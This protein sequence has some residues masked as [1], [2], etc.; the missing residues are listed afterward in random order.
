MAEFKWTDSQ[1]L[2]ISAPTDNI[3]VSAAAGSGKTAVLVERI[4]RMLSRDEHPLDIDRLVVI[5]FTRAAA[6]SMKNKI[7]KRLRD[8]C[9]E[10]P[11]NIYLRQQLMKVQHARICTIDSLCADIV[12]NNIQD[13]ELDPGFRLADEAEINLLKKDVLE[14]VLEEEYASAS[15][16]FIR[17]AQYYADKN[18]KKI[19]SIILKLHSY[20][21]SHP[22]PE[23]W[24]DAGADVYTDAGNLFA[25]E[26][27]QDADNESNWMISYRD[28][29]IS[30]LENI[31]DMALQGRNIAG[32][33]YGPFKH[34]QIFQDILSAVNGILKSGQPLDSIKGA[35][36][37]LIDKPQGS[38][39]YSEKDACDENLK[40]YAQNLRKSIREQLVSLHDDFLYADYESMCRELAECE[41]V[42]KAIINTTKR[43][44]EKL[45]QAKMDRQIAD[46]SDIAHYALR[47]LL[48]YDEKGR[49]LRDEAGHIIYTETADIMSRSIDEIIVDEYQDTNE[50]QEYLVGAL[51]SERFGRPN[52]FM[53]G[54]V[55]QSIY[56]FRM[57]CPELFTHKYDNYRHMNELADYVPYNELVDKKTPHGWLITLDMNFRS[58]REVVDITNY[59]FRQA[60][61]RDVGGIDYQQGHELVFGKQINLEEEKLE[62]YTPEIFFI[63]GKDDGKQAKYQEG[64]EIADRIEKLTADGRYSLSDIAILSRNTDNSELEQV[65][66]ERG[67]AFIKSSGKGFFDCF[68][69]RLVLNLLNIIDNPYQDIPFTAVLY[70]PICSA[71]A[72]EL[73]R[74]R[75]AGDE[76]KSIYE[77]LMAYCEESDGKFTWL[78]QKL[79]KWRS[80]AQYMSICDFMDYVMKDSGLQNI[81]SAMP[82]GR[83]RIANVELLKSKAQT[84]A[85]GSYTGL[86]NFLRYM[87]EI[88]EN[89]TDF[90]LVNAVSGDAR[91]V[92]M[93]TIH[94]S[95][96]L[97]FP[98]VFLAGCGKKYNEM[99]DRANIIPDRRLGIGIEYRDVEARLNKKT[100][101]MQTI[102]RIQKTNTYAEELRLLYVAMTRAVD[103]L[104]ISGATAGNEGLDNIIK[105]WDQEKY[106]ADGQLKSYKVMDCSSYMKVLG[107][108]LHKHQEDSKLYNLHYLLQYE[109]EEKRAT[110]L[111]ENM[112]TEDK[113][114]EIARSEMDV[115]DIE[116]QCNYKYPFDKAAHIQGKISASQLEDRDNHYVGAGA[117]GNMENP[118]NSKSLLHRDSNLNADIDAAVDDRGIDIDEPENAVRRTGRRKRGQ[119]DAATLTGADRGNAYHKFFEL[120]DYNKDI[121]QQLDEYVAAGRLSSEYAGAI[122]VSRIETFMNSDLGQRMKRAFNEGKLF[123]E[124]QFV[125]GSY[126]DI[127]QMKTQTGM[128]FS[129]SESDVELLLVQGIIDAF[130]FETAEDGSENIILVDY[131]TDKSREEGHYTKIYTPQLNEYA[132]ALEKAQGRHVT[133]KIVYSIEMGKAIH[134]H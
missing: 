105:N 100:V 51:S 96:G 28:I 131:K 2:A 45:K 107:I 49:I 36:E 122:E 74:I 5:T 124:R 113:I 84:F 99:D 56:G 17:F 116:R 115:S 126:I 57:A 75:L 103:M 24:L 91:A 25:D 27:Y 31:M 22:A 76:N 87:H 46:F 80:M 101:L 93:M 62:D 127:A 78:V 65:L 34:K 41:P 63:N 15:E 29:V 108:T 68:E 97:E 7:Y 77:C 58:R 9:R 112:I 50:L 102:R 10:H 35:V 120:L 18:D 47:V 128:S 85:R 69:I 20:S 52:V 109:T 106:F 111:I 134:C 12:R 55:K 67:I 14:E 32:R 72:D 37:A 66:R 48:K 21:E 90:G 110:E 130:F 89:G 23:A 88:Q 118:E 42:A 94:K 1:E 104:I 13:V 125:K 54:D 38:I 26:K 86:F 3:L 121:R 39:R 119:K 114:Y 40:K 60:M 19:E 44:A 70:S 43:F 82:Q 61:I 95:K 81:L 83:D 123:R 71:S 79:G 6:A 11:E 98:V 53:V 30:T 59:V 8:V 16:G 73:A 129:S 4:I 117:A 132:D 33:N 92:T 64:Y 133:E